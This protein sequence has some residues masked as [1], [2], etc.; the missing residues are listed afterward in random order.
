MIL[1][2]VPRSIVI[3]H[4]MWQKITPKYQPKTTSRRTHHLVLFLS[5]CFNLFL[6]CPP[7]GLFCRPFDVHRLDTWSYYGLTVPPA[8]SN[9]VPS[10]LLCYLSSS[11]FSFRFFF[12]IRITWYSIVGT[13]EVPHILLLTYR[14]PIS[15]PISHCCEAIRSWCSLRY[16]E[17]CSDW[18]VLLKCH[19]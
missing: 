13:Y 16:I 12:S 19:Y 2:Q 15:G 14:G 7:C 5:P 8:N 17:Y 1:V 9:L 3:H 6:T 18:H 4:A 11:L 10:R